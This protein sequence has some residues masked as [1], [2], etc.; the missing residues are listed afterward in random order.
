MGQ[1]I[2]LWE[3][4]LSQANQRPIMNKKLKQIEKIELTNGQ[5]RLIYKIWTL[6]KVME[7]RY[8]NHVNGLKTKMWIVTKDQ[9]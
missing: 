1:Y 7:K 2:N 6:E 9:L 3:Q 4:K 5:K 8:L